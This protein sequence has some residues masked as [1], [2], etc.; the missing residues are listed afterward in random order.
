MDGS[1]V[2]NHISSSRFDFF[3]MV[4]SCS[5]PLAKIEGSFT[6]S[7]SQSPKDVSHWPGLGRMVPS[8]ETTAMPERDGML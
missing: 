1:G 8:A 2:L 4:V 5:A 7:S 3:S 6:N